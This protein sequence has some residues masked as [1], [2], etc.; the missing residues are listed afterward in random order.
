MFFNNYFYNF[1]KTL[2]EA[3][4]HNDKN[5]KKITN[6]LRSLKK[7]NKVIIIG[8]GGSSAIASHVA[9]DLNKI[10]DISSLTFN[11]LSNITALSNDLNYENAFS[12]NIKFLGKK[13][14]VL[15]SISSSGDS[16]N[17]IN[18]IQ[19][20]KKLQFS[21]IITFTGMNS[22]NKV[23]KYGDINV[24]VDSHLYNFVENIHQ[25]LLLYCVDTFNKIKFKN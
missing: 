2:E 11:D 7:T 1:S 18:A 8:N 6:V 24:W 13:G 12:E 19:T 21:K 15:I 5:L 9:I 10:A 23:K 17:I 20:A 16:K 25:I 14:D 3:L 4:K 22:N